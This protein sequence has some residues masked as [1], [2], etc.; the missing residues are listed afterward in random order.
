MLAPNLPIH[1][2]HPKISD[3]TLYVDHSSYLY[4]TSTPQLVGIVAQD[5]HQDPYK[6]PVTLNIAR[7]D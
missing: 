1:L 6:T 7:V 2:H 3:A 4:C 5:N